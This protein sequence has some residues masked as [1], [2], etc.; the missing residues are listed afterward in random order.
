[1]TEIGFQ[2][3]VRVEVVGES[4]AEASGHI[5]DIEANGIVEVPERSG[6]G[7][8]GM[9]PL[10]SHKQIPLWIRVALRERRERDE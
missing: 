8:A 7:P 6:H 2:P 5:R 4:G 1:M 3:Q 9:Q 10:I